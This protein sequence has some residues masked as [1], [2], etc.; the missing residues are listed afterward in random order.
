M[1]VDT[2]GIAS[3]RRGEGVEVGDRAMQGIGIVCQ[4][5]IELAQR[6]ACRLGHAL[7][8]G[9]VGDENGGLGLRRGQMRRPGVAA[10]ER[11]HGNSGQALELQTGMGIRPHR[12]TRDHCDGRRH[13][14]QIIG[15]ELEIDDLTDANA[16]EQDRGPGQ[17]PRNIV[18]EADAV[19]GTL[20]ETAGVVQP[21]DEAEH[22]SDGRQH[23]QPDQFIGCAGFHCLSVS[24]VPF[25]RHVNAGPG[26]RT[27]P[28]GAPRRA[29][30]GSAPPRRPCR[31]PGRRCGRTRCGGCRDHGSP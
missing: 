4:Q 16:V 17:Q 25:V 18:F 21:V 6:L 9:G 20:A 1:P 30:R 23:E 22:G 28:K 5:G 15:V 29:S 13:L 10:Q 31:R 7:P 27:S 2:V 26:S 19:D 8:G 24:L 3:E 12:R 11:D 14:A